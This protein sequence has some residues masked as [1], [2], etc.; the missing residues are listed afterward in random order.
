[1]KTHDPNPKSWG[2]DP[3]PQDLP[4]SVVQHGLYFVFY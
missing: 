2:R 4:L 3:Q 1:M